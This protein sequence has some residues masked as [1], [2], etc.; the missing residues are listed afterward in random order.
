MQRTAASWSRWKRAPSSNGFG[1]YLAETL[2]TTHPEVRVVAARRA[3]PPIEQAPRAEQLER[4]GLTAGRHR[5]AASPPCSTRRASSR[6]ERRRRRQP[7]VPRTCRR[8]LEHGR[9]RGRA[10]R[11]ITLFGE[12]AA[13][14]V[15]ARALPRRSR[16][17][18]SSTRCSPSAATARCSAAPACSAAARSRSSASI[19]GGSASS[20][21]P[22]ARTLDPALDV[23]GRGPL[24]RSSARQA[25]AVG[26]PRRAGRRAR[27]PDASRSTTSWC[28]RAASRA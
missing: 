12:A 23:P 17:R 13:R 25:L 28:T 19:S 4:F 27:D 7:A 2:Q 6:D 21:R 5:A 10:S 15:L 26:D 14:A 8:V 24:R 11:G 18:P 1:A 3:R 16:R 20:P 22:P 9:R